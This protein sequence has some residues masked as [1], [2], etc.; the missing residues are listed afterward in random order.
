MFTPIRT[1]VALLP[2]LLLVACD[3]AAWN[4]PN[5]PETGDEMIYYSVIYAAPPKHLDPALSYASDESLF[6]DQIYQPPL[7]YH[8]LK[9]PYE[10]IPLAVETMPAVKFLDRDKNPLPKGS[11]AVAYTRYTLT[12]REDLRFQPHP[13]FVLDDSGAQRYLFESAEQSADYDSV[14]DFPQMASRPV[15]S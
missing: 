8:F 6:L 15:R 13:A 5:A 2:L 10:L 3:K 11:D 9:R 7:G 14:M 1:A 4:N 12:L